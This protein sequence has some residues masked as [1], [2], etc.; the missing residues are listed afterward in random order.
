SQVIVRFILGL[1]KNRFQ[2]RNLGRSGS[3]RAMSTGAFG[4]LL[5]SIFGS[6]E[7]AF[8]YND[9]VK[10]DG[11]VFVEFG[12]RVRL[13]KSGYSI[14]DK[15]HRAIVAYD[16]TFLVDPKNFDLV[17][18]TGH[19]DQIP[20]E[21]NTCAD[22]TTVE[23]SS[24]HLAWRYSAWRVPAQSCSYRPAASQVLLVFA[25]GVHYR[26]HRR[27]DWIPARILDGRPPRLAASSHLKGGQY[28]E[29][30]RIQAAAYR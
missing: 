19:A 11:R 9:S 12:F 16:G 3:G 10:V 20:A 7:A 5:P 13:E 28:S 6:T 14:T 29:L 8:T 27:R 23:Y 1:A 22:T 26:R 18:L 25:A 17:R 21:L 15:Q 2:D 30:Y 24:V 4:C